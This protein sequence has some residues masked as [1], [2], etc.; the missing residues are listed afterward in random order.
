MI[1]FLHELAEMLV[2]PCCWGQTSLPVVVW[3]L[4]AA[5]ACGMCELSLVAPRLYKEPQWQIQSDPLRASSE[6]HGRHA[7]IVLFPLLGRFA[8]IFSADSGEEKRDRNPNHEGKKE[9]AAAGG[10]M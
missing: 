9:H 7:Q 10:E 6:A 5:A 8:V 2:L 1:V 4:G 3:S